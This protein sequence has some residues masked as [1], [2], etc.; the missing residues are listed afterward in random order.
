[1]EAAQCRY[2]ATRH[3]LLGA[4]RA[5]KVSSWEELV[6]DL[7]HDPWAPPISETVEPVFLD[8]VIGT[9]FPRGGEPYL[10]F[11]RPPFPGWS[12]EECGV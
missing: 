12:E 9:L 2:R 1:M 3:A 5:A 8:R 11:P 10:D 7:D 4:I 6:P